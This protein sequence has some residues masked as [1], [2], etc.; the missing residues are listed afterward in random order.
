MS[1]LSKIIAQSGETLVCM[2]LCKPQIIVGLVFFIVRLR[3]AVFLMTF[4]VI[5]FAGGS[6]CGLPTLFL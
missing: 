4:F 6:G 5:F 1:R 3:C 2:P